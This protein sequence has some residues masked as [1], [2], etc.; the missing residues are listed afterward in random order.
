[1]KAIQR[2]KD[3]KADEL[4][5]QQLISRACRAYACFVCTTVEGVQHRHVQKTLAGFDG[6]LPFV[7]VLDKMKA[8]G[9]SSFH[10]TTMRTTATEENRANPHDTMDA[11]QQ[12]I[13]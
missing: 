5:R 7:D 9:H 3:S 2:I 6:L 10:H 1:M 4:H 13:G 12:R 11:L 8:E